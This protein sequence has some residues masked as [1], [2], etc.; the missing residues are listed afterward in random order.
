METQDDKDE[1]SPEGCA[2]RSPAEL[3]PLHP[4]LPSSRELPC[5]AQAQT[6]LL[7]LLIDDVRDRLTYRPEHDLFSA[8]VLPTRTISRSE[9]R[10]RRPLVLGSVLVLGPSPRVLGSTYATAHNHRQNIRLFATTR[11][12]ARHVTPLTRGLTASTLPSPSILVFGAAAIDLQSRTTNKLFPRSTTPGRIFVSPGGVARNMAEAAQALAEPNAVKLIFAAAQD[13]LGALLARE[14]QIC[15]LRTDGIVHRSG[16]SATAACTLV[17]DEAG[18]LVNGVSDMAIVE[19]IMPEEVR[20]FKI[21]S[22]RPAID[23]FDRS[24]TLYLNTRDPPRDFSFSTAT[25]LWRV[26]RLSWSKERDWV[27]RVSSHS[28]LHWLNEQYSAS[29]PRGQ[30]C[31][32]RSPHFSQAVCRS[33]TLRPMHSSSEP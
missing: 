30:S 18:D 1:N 17:L 22:L 12:S 7:T 27:F 5:I 31:Y 24:H 10:H 23:S 20:Q 25:L 4:R 28:C 32:A 6:H 14:M 2:V 9:H 15:G 16:E 26:Y 19:T 21:A 13:P 29:R 3:F 11:L 33:T 8:S